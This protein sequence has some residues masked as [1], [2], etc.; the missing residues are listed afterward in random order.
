[1][2]THHFALGHY[3]PLP[4]GLPTLKRGRMRSAIQALRRNRDRALQ[5][6]GC[7]IKT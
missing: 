3:L 7:P 5:L 1:M 2:G 6:Q 4:L